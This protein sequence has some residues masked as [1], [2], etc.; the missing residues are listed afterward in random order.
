MTYKFQARLNSEW[1]LEKPSGAVFALGE[2]LRLLAA[3]DAVGHIAGAC[4]S[5][6]ISYRHAWGLLRHAEKEFG[7]A[8]LET[9]RR[10]GSKLTDFARHL[11]WA[12]RRMDARLTPM[13]ESMASELQEELESLYPESRP[14]LRL[15]A[16]HGFAVEGLMQMANDQDMS[17]VELRYRT[18]FEALASL[19]RGECDLAGFQVPAGEFEDAILGHYSP[20]LDGER[21]CLIYLAQRDTGMFVQPGNPKQI[22]TIAD[23]VKPGVRFVNRQ[24]GSSTRLLVG[25]MLERLGIDTRRIQGYDSSEFTHM[26]IA[27]HIASGMADAGIGVETAAW[28]CGLD[29]I[30]LA[31]ERYFFAVQRDSLESPLMRRLLDLLDSEAYRGYVSQLVGYDAADIGKVLS[32]QQAFGA[33]AGRSAAR[34]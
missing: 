17:P 9:S 30:P 16:S 19:N 18:A 5:C 31:K 28:R 13:L 4:R 23:L 34:A 22:H 6:G 7:M 29:F 10:Q 3:I 11:L 33:A 27:A 12:N 21:H 2:I 20:R 32:L 15:H 26:A 24:V 14:R 1:V 8:L 25:L